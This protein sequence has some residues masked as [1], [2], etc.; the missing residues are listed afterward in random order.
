MVKSNWWMYSELPVPFRSWAW[1]WRFSFQTVHSYRYCYRFPNPRP[2]QAAAAPSLQLQPVA[3]LSM[4]SPE[5]HT[6]KHTYAARIH[7]VDPPATGLR[8]SVCSGAVPASQSPELVAC[9]HTSPWGHGPTPAA[10]VD[11]H[12]GTDTHCVWTGLD[13]RI[14]RQLPWLLTLCLPQRCRWKHTHTHTHSHKK[15]SSSWPPGPVVSSAVGQGP[16][17]LHSAPPHTRT[18]TQ[19][20]TEPS[21]GKGGKNGV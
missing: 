11:P 15:G 5:A 10:G 8:H 2:Q 4:N 13:T 21:P 16:L 3:R 18:L 6:H 7:K 20:H 1:S 14:T 9:G 17:V 12:I 19:M